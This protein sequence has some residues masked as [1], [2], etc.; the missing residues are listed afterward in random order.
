[1]KI[2]HVVHGFP[3][4]RRGGT[5]IYT[6]YLSKELS[7][8][9][10]VHILYPS[11][12][13][14]II[15]YSPNKYGNHGLHI[16]E[17]IIEMTNN[18]L[19]FRKVKELIDPKHTYK[20]AKIDRA[21]ALL[22]DEIDPDIVHF[23]HLIDLSA[24][25]IEVVKERGIPAVLT[26]HDF[27]FICPM[28][29][30]LRSD[31]S[32]CDGSD[33][34]FENCLKCWNKAQAKSLAGFM[35][36]YSIPRVLAKVF[37]LAEIAINRGRIMERN[38]YMKSLLLKL[39]KLIAP[40]RFL[41]DV[42]IQ[43]GIPEEKII[44]SN[45]GY[46]LSAFAGFRKREHDKL[47]FGFVGAVGMQKGVHVLVEAFNKVQRENVEL[48]IYGDYNPRSN[49]FKELQAKAKNHRIKFMG[50]FEDVK[51]PYSEIDVLV[52]PSIWYETGGPLVA[53]EAF[54]AKT[55]VIASNIGCIPEFLED[56]K[57]GLLF[58]AGNADHL[59]EEMKAFIENPNLV[60]EFSANIGHIKT[61]GEQAREIERIYENI[62]IETKAN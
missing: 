34:E 51:W 61:I 14:E 24:S 2:L 35:A 42:F 40:S 6:Y 7:N 62:L 12:D 8:N 29:T 41:R 33:E 50:R 21:F 16:V 56:G 60:K 27:W 37:E 57:T 53:T 55:P 3:P 1:M 11:K 10:E 20:N 58:E 25:L 4:E 5:E 17:H 23:Q 26:L 19:F 52:I 15:A 59:L 47:I 36:K 9:H 30:L 39:D 49:Y 31:Y 38:E 32:I 45:N 48:R 28:I 13:P 54:I 44:Y 43:H 46:D 22:L 18:Q